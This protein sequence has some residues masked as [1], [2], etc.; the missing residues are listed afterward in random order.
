MG[1]S[2]KK[3]DAIRANLEAVAAARDDVVRHGQQLALDEDFH[4]VLPAGV[5][6]A[7]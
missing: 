7:A 6:V 2:F 5:N 4:V 1:A 3:A